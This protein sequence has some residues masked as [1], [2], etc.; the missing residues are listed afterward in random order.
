[1]EIMGSTFLWWLNRVSMG[2]INNETK[3]TSA[4]N[5]RKLCIETIS[6][7]VML[8]LPEIGADEKLHAVIT[9]EWNMS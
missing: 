6:I 8:L 7:V 1:M 4:D 3:N 5:E 9:V 2:N